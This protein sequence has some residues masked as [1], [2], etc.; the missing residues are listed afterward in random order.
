MSVAE[1]LANI[2]QSLEQEKQQKA[3]IAEEARLKPIRQRIQALTKYLESLA[4]IKNSL[5]LKADDKLGAGLGMKDYSDLT[6][7]KIDTSS[8]KLDATMANEP[9]ALSHLGIKNR[10]QLVKHPNF[11]DDE[12]VLDYQQALTQGH[13]L[14]IDDEALQ[15]RLTNLGVKVEAD[16][17][18]YVAAQQALEEKLQAANSELLQAKLQTPEGRA[19]AQNS[20]AEDFQKT[21]PTLEF[22]YNERQGQAQLVLGDNYRGPAATVAADG[23]AKLTNWREARLL[24]PDFNDRAA[25]YGED[26]AAAAAQQAYKTKLHNSVLTNDQRNYQAFSLQEQLTH[27]NPEQ[28]YLAEALLR[29]FIDAQHKFRQTAQQKSLELKKKKLDFDPEYVSGGYKYE[30][31]IALS[32][33]ENADDLLAEIHRPTKFP[34]NYDYQ[35]LQELT[36]TRLAFLDKFTGII[37]NLQTQAD[38]DKL[39][40]GSSKPDVEA[41]VSTAYHEASIFDLDEAKFKFRDDGRTVDGRSSVADLL[42]KSQGYSGAKDYLDRR[43]KIVT[44]AEQKILDAVELAVAAHLKNRELGEELQKY[45]EFKKEGN[46][47]ENFKRDMERLESRAKEAQEILRRLDT[48]ETKLPAGELVLEQGRVAAPAKIKE[49]SDL[50]KKIESAR[51]ELQKTENLLRERQATKPKIFGQQKWQAELDVLEKHQQELTEQIGAD[52]KQRNRL[53]DQ[54]YFYFVPNN[55]VYIKNDITTQRAQGSAQE[56]FKD[57][58]IQMAKLVKYELPPRSAQLYQEY[59]ALEEKLK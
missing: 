52:S 34:P 9:A 10:E 45:P 1:K 42:S 40:T 2:A 47:A 29:Q 17:F 22:S 24:P 37:E 53:D 20:L 15:A 48:L 39:T 4:I 27:I 14:K 44:T 56:I 23:S 49:S 16:N 19:E 55:C 28:A 54:S 46:A 33:N 30:H 32:R 11:K 25:I 57:L 41:Q 21:I 8:K 6:A 51:Q 26:L 59:R 3:N 35:K 18:S 50:G 31:I 13:D 43:V 58:R 7:E 36:K 12:E 38:L 5:N